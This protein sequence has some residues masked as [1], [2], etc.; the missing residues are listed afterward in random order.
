MMLSTQ[1]QAAA[2]AFRFQRDRPSKEAFPRREV[3]PHVPLTHLWSTKGYRDT[4]LRCP[5][6]RDSNSATR[7]K[8]NPAFPAPRFIGCR[9]RDAITSD[10][11]VARGSLA[12]VVSAARLC[13]TGLAARRQGNAHGCFRRRWPRW[14]GLD[15]SCRWEVATWDPQ[16]TSRAAGAGPGPWVQGDTLSAGA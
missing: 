11:A 5:P 10:V 13:G 16:T 3:S 4:S 15:R 9:L 14:A 1:K 6:P 12:P 7:F 2:G 8:P